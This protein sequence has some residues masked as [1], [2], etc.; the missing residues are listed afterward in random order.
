MG[1]SVCV[2]SDFLHFHTFVK[3]RSVDVGDDLEKMLATTQ[4]YI[5]H[6]K[7]IDAE[8][9]HT[10]AIPADFGVA[11]S[12]SACDGALLSGRGDRR[13]RNCSCNIAVATLGN[14]MCNNRKL[15]LQQSETAFATIGNCICNNAY[16]S[17]FIAS[18]VC[19]TR[20]LHVQQSGTA[21]ATIRN[22]IRSAKKLHW[23]LLEMVADQP[24]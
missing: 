12:E 9:P 17:G 7:N 11:A 6:V 23:Q 1:G 10:G 4:R 24:S 14:C 18:C 8:Q 20:K 5:E 22:C 21:F 19:N 15:H 13:T 3:K 2:A 16:F